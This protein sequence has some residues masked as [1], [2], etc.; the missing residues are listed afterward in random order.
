M[1]IK[2]YKE[3]IN[4][5]LINKCEEREDIIYKMDKDEKFKFY[6][7]AIYIHLYFNELKE[8]IKNIEKQ[9]KKKFLNIIEK[10]L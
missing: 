6:A 9:E 4:E 10:H 5:F 2:T 1:P 8:N 7:S 3:D